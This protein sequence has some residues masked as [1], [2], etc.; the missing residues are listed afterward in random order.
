VKR[1]AKPG[2][3]DRDAVLKLLQRVSRARAALHRDR[4]S[5]FVDVLVSLTK[6]LPYEAAESVAATLIVAAVEIVDRNERRRGSRP[7]GP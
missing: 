4:R 5:P 7:N 2:D 6:G 3:P 1:T